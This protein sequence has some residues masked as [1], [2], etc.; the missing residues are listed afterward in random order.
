[1]SAENVADVIET[2]WQRAH[3]EYRESPTE[4]LD[5]YLDGLDYAIYLM[6]RSK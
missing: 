6:G 3:G 5:G 2:E 4:Y 1:M